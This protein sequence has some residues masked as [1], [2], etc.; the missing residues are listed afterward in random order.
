ME[1]YVLQ[2]S[3]DF[4]LN[5]GSVCFFS[6]RFYHADICNFG[7]I[8]AKLKLDSLWQTICFPKLFPT[9]LIYSNLG[10]V[11]HPMHIGSIWT[12]L[13]RFCIRNKMNNDTNVVS[14]IFVRSFLH[15]FFRFYFL[16]KIGQY[17]KWLNNWI[18][19]AIFFW[20]IFR[21]IATNFNTLPAEVFF[22]VFIEKIRANT[23]QSDNRIPIDLR[24]ICQQKFSSQQSNWPF[25]EVVALN[26]T[27]I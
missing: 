1:L 9:N 27:R 17:L 20:P 22:P 15:N 5:F 18:K 7:Q 8:Q 25:G 24:T 23:N 11:A 21:K 16:D 6:G 3:N 10:K 13:Y 14:T 4:Y 26:E 12:Q 2:C 19:F